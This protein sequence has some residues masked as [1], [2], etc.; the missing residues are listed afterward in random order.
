[1]YNGTTMSPLG[2]SIFTCAKGEISKDVDFFI[3][4][5]DVRPLLGAET[6]QELNLIKVMVYDM[7]DPETV[8]SVNDKP[9]TN[10]LT[11]DRI[12]KDFSDV[13]EGLGC[14]DSLYHRKVDE[15]VKPVI[16]PPRKV[17]VA[18]RDRLKE[19]LEKLV[20]KEVITP[21]TEPT[22]WVSRM[23]LV[24]KPDKVRTCIDPQDLNKA[25]Y[26]LPTIE[27]VATRL[28]KAKGRSS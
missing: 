16:H 6:C 5:L 8:N 11:K 12:L 2:K 22:N 18:L 9:Q 25:H 10:V 7:L 28:S 20:K 1:M 24:N 4:D 21:V 27:E 13:F 23:V 19:E 26:P 15:N 3:V 17:H 14:M